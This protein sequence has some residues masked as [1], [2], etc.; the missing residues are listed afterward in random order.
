MKYIRAYF[1][2]FFSMALVISVAFYILNLAFNSNGFA[3]LCLY[4]NIVSAIAGPLGVWL[5]EGRK[6]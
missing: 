1:H 4:V 2:A 3:Y 5:S 6:E